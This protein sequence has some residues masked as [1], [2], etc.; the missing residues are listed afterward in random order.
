[1]GSLRRA[2]AARTPTRGLD[3]LG[4]EMSSR[5]WEHCYGEKKVMLVLSRQLQQQ[6][7][8]DERIT[9]TILKTRGKTVRIGIEAPREVR[10]RRGELPPETGCSRARRSTCPARSGP[11]RHPQRWSVASMQLRAH[12]ANATDPHVEG[13]SPAAS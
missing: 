6:I 5:G 2:G 1:M 7:C 13:A 10:V 8:I 3:P 12:S 11:D 4:P 9:L